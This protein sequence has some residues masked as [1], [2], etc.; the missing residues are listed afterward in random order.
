MIPMQAFLNQLS[1][2]FP[3][4]LFT[5]PLYPNSSSK[6]VSKVSTHWHMQTIKRYAYAFIHLSANT[7]LD[8]HKV[9]SFS[10]HCFPMAVLP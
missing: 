3:K 1:Y 5:L 6:L 8:P 2:N 10:F 7:V 4:V 9:A